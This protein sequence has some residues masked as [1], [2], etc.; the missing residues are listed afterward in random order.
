MGQH[1]AAGLLAWS[2][3]RGLSQSRIL[4]GVCGREAGHLCVEGF[5]QVVLM[6]HWSGER[7]LA[8]G[9]VGVTQ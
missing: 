7:A 1:P 9:E 2:S 4:R 8:L 5:S 3:E 6:P